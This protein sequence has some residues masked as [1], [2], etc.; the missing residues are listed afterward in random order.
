MNNLFTERFSELLELHLWSYEQLA[1][2]LGLKSK[3]TICKYAQGKIKNVNTS[4]VIKI[5]NLYKVSPTWLIGLD[6]NKVCCSNMNKDY[7]IINAIDSNGNT[8]SDKIVTLKKS[9]SN[10]NYTAFKCNDISMSPIINPSDLLL[11][12]L[13]CKPKNGDLCLIS[14]SGNF[15]IRKLTKDSNK[16]IFNAINPNFKSLSSSLDDNASNSVNIIG[17]VKKLERTNFQKN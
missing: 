10:N 11:I 15:M 6:D 12:E 1:Q 13:N 5:A 7:T 3:G 16:F 9:K 2:K 17:I 4:M 14:K 8:L